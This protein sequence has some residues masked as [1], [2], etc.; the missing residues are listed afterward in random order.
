MKRLLLYP[1]TFL[2]LLSCRKNHDKPDPEHER[3]RLKSINFNTFEYDDQGRLTRDNVSNSIVAY[4]TYTYSKDSVVGT[5]FDRQGNPHAGGGV[6]FYLGANGLA[7]REKFIFDNTTP[8][9][10]IDFTY[11]ADKQLTQEIIREEGEEP[12]SKIMMFYSHG[13]MDSSRSVSLKTGELLRTVYYHY[14]TDQANLL[15]T[16]HNGISYLGKGNANLEKSNIQVIPG[17]NNI[18]TESGYEFD[19]KGRPSARHTRVDGVAFNDQTFTW[20]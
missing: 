5:D 9:F 13:N 7:T 18:L 6:I 1:L 17:I 4:T 16:E 8:A 3:V 20:F 2:L 15:D 11:N 14:Y 12:E 19:D 10:V